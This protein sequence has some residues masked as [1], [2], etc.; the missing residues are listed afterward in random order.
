MDSENA[1]QAPR[2]SPAEPLRPVVLYDGGC[3]RCRREI[4]Y[5]QRLRGADRLDWIDVHGQPQALAGTGIDWQ[6]AMREFHLLDSTGRWHRGVAAFAELWR[7]FPRWRWLAMLVRLPGV[8][9]LLDRAYRRWAATR[10]ACRMQQELGE[11]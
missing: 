10:F 1:A 7:H 11:S 6:E 3:P 9:G 4:K 8:H 5:Y 2:H